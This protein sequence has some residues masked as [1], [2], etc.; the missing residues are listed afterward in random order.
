MANFDGRDSSFTVCSGNTNFE[1]GSGEEFLENCASKGPPSPPLEAA[2]RGV[3]SAGSAVSQQR[4]GPHRAPLRSHPHPI[5]GGLP[6]EPRDQ[7][8]GTAKTECWEILAF[9]HFLDYRATGCPPL[10]GNG[11]YLCNG[12]NI[13]DFTPTPRHAIS[14]PSV[15]SH[16]HFLAHR[17]GAMAGT[18]SLPLARTLNHT[19]QHVGQWRGG[20]HSRHAHRTHDGRC[21]SRCFDVA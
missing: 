20:S 12:S 17:A 5:C 1:V 7:A 11:L 10:V 2:A 9:L 4:A 21:P 19:S 16:L 13:M 3:T 15:A 18:L 6:D 14:S 8:T